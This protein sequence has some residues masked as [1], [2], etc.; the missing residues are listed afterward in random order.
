MYNINLTNTF[1]YVKI[2]N[3]KVKKWIAVVVFSYSYVCS[4]AAVK[5]SMI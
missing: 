5:H 4:Y 2:K 1:E 3:E